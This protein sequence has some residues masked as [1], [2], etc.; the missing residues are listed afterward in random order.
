M[1]LLLINTTPED[2]DQEIPVT[3][4]GQDYR[5]RLWFSES[6]KKYNL[7]LKREGETLISN[8]RLNTG[9]IPTRKHDIEGFEGDFVLVPIS[10]TPDP[11]SRDNVGLD[12]NYA[13]VYFLED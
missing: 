2:Y 1:T 5:I 10:D 9:S 7:T 13:L 4:N 8:L 11:P 6:V 3:L 12:K